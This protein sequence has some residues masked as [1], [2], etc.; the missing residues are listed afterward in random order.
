MKERVKIGLL[1]C[2]GL[3]NK[4]KAISQM[5]RE[6]YDQ[7]S[8]N[9]ASTVMVNRQNSMH[10]TSVMNADPFIS[11]FINVVCPSSI[12]KDDFVLR[13]SIW[14]NYSEMGLISTKNHMVTM[15]L[16]HKCNSN[17]IDPTPDTILLSISTAIY[18]NLISMIPT[19]LSYQILLFKFCL[20][21]KFK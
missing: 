11:T 19:I 10:Y 12:H 18:I 5:H 17:S 16:C 4:L 13:N 20:L 1:E 21:E 7:I 6:E 8:S 3:R 2:N 15:L 9:T 14:Y